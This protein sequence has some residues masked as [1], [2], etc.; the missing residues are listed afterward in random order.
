MMRYS[1]L[2]KPKFILLQA[3]LLLFS[4]CMVNSLFPFYTLST[5]YF[6]KTIVG[7][8][9]LDEFEDITDTN[10]T[11]D[12]KP[13]QDLDINDTTN[14]IVKRLSPE[15]L[16]KYKEKYRGGY[17]AYYEQKTDE[18]EWDGFPN[19]QKDYY[20]QNKHKSKGYLIAMPFKI[21]NQ[22]FIDFTPICNFSQQRSVIS[23][24]DLNTI[25]THT[26]AK[27]DV[28]SKNRID[29]CWFPESNVDSLIKVGRLKIKHEKYGINAFFNESIL[30]TASTEELQGFIKKYMNS[31]IKNKWIIYDDFKLRRFNEKT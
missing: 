31:N 15:Q 6:E 19:W 21:N 29:L 14:D 30:L 17:I 22:L 12:F 2:L 5:I 23:L 7:K 16:K 11:W 27:V 20:N 13:V 25:E 24:Y 4:S 9:G 26:L 1:K 18:T 3:M 8:W 10:T 28:I